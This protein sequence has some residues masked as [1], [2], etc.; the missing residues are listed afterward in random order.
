[1]EVEVR[2]HSF[3]AVGRCVL[4]GGEQMRVHP[5]A[6]RMYSAGVRMRARDTSGVE[7]ASSRGRPPVPTR[8]E[9]RMV[10]EAFGS[11]GGW[12]E[13]A[14]P[15]PGEVVELE[16]DSDRSYFVNR[17]NWLGSS[18]Q[19]SLEPQ[20]RSGATAS[21][22]P[23]YDLGVIPGML[24]EGSGRVVLWALGGGEIVDLAPGEGVVV[25]S[26]YVVGYDLVT[27]CTMHA[28]GGPGSRGGELDD[29][30]SLPS[31]A[32]TEFVGPGRLVLQARSERAMAAWTRSIVPNKVVPVTF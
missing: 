29:G 18:E 13:L 27:R 26:S 5:E 17:R 21:P 15:L 30:P 1:M 23:G 7:Q 20:L 22:D 19:V 24:V 4:A 9:F 10:A 3:S 14:A 16:I 6:V 32:F 11:G 12:L 2:R 25:E 31:K 8:P 28:S